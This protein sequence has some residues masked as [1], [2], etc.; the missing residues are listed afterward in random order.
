MVANEVFKE[1]YKILKNSGHLFKE[2]E[3]FFNAYPTGDYKGLKSL[4]KKHN[5]KGVSLCIEDGVLK[6][7]SSIY[8]DHLTVVRYHNEF[9][10]YPNDTVDIEPY[11]EDNAVSLKTL[12]TDI[13]TLLALKAEV[14]SATEIVEFIKTIKNVN[15]FEK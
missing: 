7:F 4:L 2:Y 6:T 14:E 10:L 1:D 8:M 12:T 9:I 13:N 3:E 11:N 15:Y 5:I